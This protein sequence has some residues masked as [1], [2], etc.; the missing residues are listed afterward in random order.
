MQTLSDAEVAALYAG[1]ELPTMVAKTG[2]IAASGEKPET[3]NYW[4]L[5]LAVVVI[6]AVA[7]GLAIRKKKPTT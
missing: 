6:A 4:M 5:V 3:S 2:I 1:K 7:V